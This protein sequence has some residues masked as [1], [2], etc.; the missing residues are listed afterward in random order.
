MATTL[1]PWTR[2]TKWIAAIIV[3]SASLIGF[4]ASPATAATETT[5]FDNGTVLCW[6]T[7]SSSPGWVTVK[8]P[9]FFTSSALVGTGKYAYTFDLKIYDASWRLLRTIPYTAS[10][11][12]RAYLW[13]DSSF[14]SSAFSQ[15]AGGNG[16]PWYL[17]YGL[18]NPLRYY[19]SYNV[20][21]GY[22]VQ[23]AV[24]LWSDLRRAWVQSGYALNDRNF[25]RNYCDTSTRVVSI[26]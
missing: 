16:T 19:P 20:G 22:N 18:T 12:T 15:T 4:A 2:L 6:E 5:P 9:T 24:W 8:P 11:G 23:V 25:N 14:Y 3:A 21:V 10:N 13:S 1:H 7:N 26:Y 17:D